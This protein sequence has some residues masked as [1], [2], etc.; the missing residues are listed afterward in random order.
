MKVA[1]VTVG[2]ELLVPG[3]TDTNTPW[4]T[5]KLAAAG[6]EVTFRATVGDDEERIAESLRLALRGADL[7][8]ST[9][10]LGPTSDDLTRE[11]AARLL[12]LELVLKEPTLEEIRRR[13]DERGIA[14]PAVNRKQAMVPA[15]AEILENE[16]GTAP[17]L[18]IA[19]AGKP[20]KEVALLPGPPVELHPMFERSVL[21]RLVARS[22][23]TVYRTRKLWIV[24][25]PE[26]AV[27]QLVSDAY[28]ACENPV[29]TILAAPGQ[30]E[31][32]LTAQGASV[33]EADERNEELAARLRGILGA[34]VF[35]ESEEELEEV[36]GRLLVEKGLSLGVAESVTGGLIA[37][38]ITRV[39]GSSRYFDLGVVT[40]SNE[41]KTELLGV[42]PG[43]FEDVGAV[44]EDVARSMAA[45]IRRRSGSDL[46]IATTGIAGPGG[47]T[48]TKR[49]G[50]VYIAVSGP[51]VEEVERY[52]FPGQRVAVKRWASQAALNRVR[53]VLLKGR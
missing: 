17:G 27:E 50:L 5:D 35:S 31:L 34:H 42:D 9:G 24:G 48:P 22:G 15:G 44:S 2:S 45:G 26:S 28:R 51:G 3:R 7:V 46:G 40:Y 38:R 37:H 1:I 18:W 43:L 23:A 30:V 13:F 36:V 6:V 33:D 12:G 49:V 25:L 11:A 16:V 4:L 14:M 10:G 19:N 53:L 41:A 21:P 29:T 20:G 52:Q 47:A 8:L 32:R 39:A